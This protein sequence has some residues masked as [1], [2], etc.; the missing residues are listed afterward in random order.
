MRKSGKPSSKWEL[1]SPNESRLT[2]AD[3]GGSHPH[4]PT[5]LADSPSLSGERRDRSGLGV[6]CSVREHDPHPFAHL[7]VLPHTNYHTCRTG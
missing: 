3:G 7:Y 5:G 2:G 4:L 6:G 1:S